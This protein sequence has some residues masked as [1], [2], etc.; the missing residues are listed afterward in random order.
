MLE[1]RADGFIHDVTQHYQNLDEAT[2]NRPAPTGGWSI[3]QCLAHLNSYGDYYLPLLSQAI[4]H[5]SGRPA[6]GMF[7]S[8]W[9]GTYLTRLM[10]PQTSSKQ[11]KAVKR[12]IPP[13]NLAAHEVVATFIDQMETLLRLLRLA[14]TV[15]LRAARIPLSVAGWVRLPLGDV[16]QFMIAHTDRHLQQ[17][18]QNR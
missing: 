11:F 8:S 14:E 18:R 16:L 17:A 15:D 7:A 1:E 5:P 3:A 10:D 2:L 9:L 12:H 6:A 4:N 13:S